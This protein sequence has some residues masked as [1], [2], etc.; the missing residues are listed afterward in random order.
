[1]NEILGQLLEN[2]ETRVHGVMNILLESPYFYR[3]DDEELFLF[4]SRYRFDFEKHFRK[5]FNW[6][7][8]IDTKCAR[9][10][11]DKWYNKSLTEGQRSRFHLSKRDECLAFIMLLEFFEHQVEEH[12]LRVDEDD[13]LKFYYKDFHQYCHKRFL[14][15]YPNEAEKYKG[16]S[17]RSNILRKLFDKLILNR[18]LA[19]LPAPEHMSVKA[20]EVIYEALPA[21]YHY[22]AAEL[23]ANFDEKE[24]GYGL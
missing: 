21:L 5:Y 1:M 12:D 8:I 9:L 22:N 13:N 4:L 16:E 2:Q 15:L 10:Y 3:K 18:F 23:T 14:E 6:Q 19:K 20:D 11:K 24:E 17:I 7:L